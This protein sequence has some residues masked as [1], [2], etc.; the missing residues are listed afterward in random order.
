MAYFTDLAEQVSKIDKPRSKFF[1]PDGEEDDVYDEV[2]D[3]EEY[4]G[5]LMDGYE[6]DDEFADE[7]EEIAEEDEEED[8]EEEDEEDNDDAVMDGNDEI[9]GGAERRKVILREVPA[10]LSAPQDDG[11]QYGMC[12]SASL[13]ACGGGIFQGDGYHEE[14]ISKPSAVVRI[15]SELNM[16]DKR[17][18]RNEAYMSMKDKTGDTG[19]VEEVEPGEENWDKTGGHWSENNGAVDLVCFKI[20]DK[21]KQGSDCANVALVKNGQDIISKVMEKTACSVEPNTTSLYKPHDKSLSTPLRVEGFG[22]KS[23]KFETG[24]TFLVSK[25]SLSASAVEKIA[26]SVEQNTTLLYKPDNKSLSAPLVEGFLGKNKDLETSKTFLASK[27]GV[28]GIGRLMKKNYME[29]IIYAI[30]HDKIKAYSTAGTPKSTHAV[31]ASV[32]TYAV[33]DD[34]FEALTTGPFQDN[35]LSKIP[36]TLSSKSSCLTCVVREEKSYQASSTSNA[37]ASGLSSVNEESTFGSELE[38]LLT[39]HISQES[40]DDPSSYGKLLVSLEKG[41]NLETLANQGLS[42]SIAACSSAENFSFTKLFK[43]KTDGMTSSVNKTK[44]ST[45]TVKRNGKEIK[46]GR[47][48]RFDTGCAQKCI[49]TEIFLDEHQNLAQD[50]PIG[51][52]LYEDIEESSAHCCN[53]SAHEVSTPNKLMYS[54]TFSKTLAALRA[55]KSPKSVSRTRS[56]HGNLEG[57][58]S[59]PLHRAWSLSELHRKTVSFKSSEAVDKE[60]ANAQKHH[61]N[62]SEEEQPREIPSDNIYADEKCEDIPVDYRF[63][64]LTPCGTKSKPSI[65]SKGNN[66]TPFNLQDKKPQHLEVKRKFSCS[67]L[68]M[69]LSPQYFEKNK[70]D[71]ALCSQKLPEIFSTYS[72][73]KVIMMCDISAAATVH[74]SRPTSPSP[75][76]TNSVPDVRMIMKMASENYQNVTKDDKLEEMLWCDMPVSGEVDKFN[77]M[78]IYSTSAPVTSL[79]RQEGGPNLLNLQDKEDPNARV[80]NAFLSLQMPPFLSP[81]YFQEKQ[82]LCTENSKEKFSFDELYPSTEFKK[83][84]TM[85]DGSETTFRLDQHLNGMNNSILVS[86]PNSYS[87]EKSKTDADLNKKAGAQAFPVN[88]SPQNLIRDGLHTA[89]TSFKVFYENS[90]LKSVKLRPNK[91]T[92]ET[93]MPGKGPETTGIER[94]CKNLDDTA[95]SRIQTEIYKGDVGT[96]Q[97]QL[98]AGSHEAAAPND[99]EDTLSWDD[100][101]THPV[102]KNAVSAKISGSSHI[103]C[104][105]HFLNEE[106]SESETDGSLKTRDIQVYRD[107]GNKSKWFFEKGKLINPALLKEQKK[108]RGPFLRKLQENTES[109]LKAFLEVEQGSGRKHQDIKIELKQDGS[110]D[111]CQDMK[112]HSSGFELQNI[113]TKEERDKHGTGVLEALKTL[114][115]TSIRSSELQS[116]S[117][118][119]MTVSPSLDEGEFGSEM[120]QTIYDFDDMEANRTGL[121]QASKA[122]PLSRAEIQEIIFESDS[123][124]DLKIISPED[125]EQLLQNYQSS[126]L[127]ITISLPTANEGNFERDWGHGYEFNTEGMF[128]VKRGIL[129]P[130]RPVPQS[131]SIFFSRSQSNLELTV[132]SLSEACTSP[133]SSLIAAYVPKSD[134]KKTEQESLKIV[135]TKAASLETDG[136]N[137]SPKRKRKRRKLGQIG[138]KEGSCDDAELKTNTSPALMESDKSVQRKLQTNTKKEKCS[139]ERGHNRAVKT[140]VSESRM[141]RKI[142]VQSTILRKREPKTKNQVKELEQRKTMKRLKSDSKD[143]RSTG[144]AK[145]LWKECVKQCSNGAVTKM[146]ETTE[147]DLQGVRALIDP[148]ES[149]T[150][151]HRKSRKDSVLHSETLNTL[152]EK[153]HLQVYQEAKVQTD[154]GVNFAVER[155]R[156]SS[157]QGHISGGNLKCGRPKGSKCKANSCAGQRRSCSVGAQPVWLKTEVNPNSFRITSSRVFHRDT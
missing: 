47:D 138:E 122:A 86:W 61:Q 85:F 59:L 116:D 78:P 33:I 71:Q 27:Q 137:Q 60:Q 46:S 16:G 113:R 65:N 140:N 98:L 69:Y 63:A 17:E 107:K 38:E 92:P 81:Q 73:C 24:K 125:K 8:E 150:Q 96:Q 156:G 45:Q 7:D 1:N 95:A 80:S 52:K 119:C 151:R 19:L 112:F 53:G 139:K 103:I 114:G 87:S 154:G 3:D 35:T 111:S 22:G 13:R 25:R 4:P 100:V 12:A 106:T 15:C 34:T 126:T 90:M 155:F 43:E 66:Q 21:N 32:D 88:T 121:L 143:S 108:S 124:S 48:I 101:I 99:S 149:Q 147:R 76:N 57:S 30:N 94:V 91:S 41:T 84:T 14:E 109:K 23:K 67:K 26:N 39:V 134:T 127:N 97:N 2:D 83:A 56:L 75:Q 70:K 118:S 153:K 68:P 157:T 9:N 10:V 152:T 130:D 104:D 148:C 28:C 135:M 128:E 54:L 77:D 144:N 50:K 145:A 42:K 131:R 55:S 132:S 58:S 120:P 44:N 31:C 82:I 89:E 36:D 49:E 40:L 6:E 141:E 102:A 142:K 72:N 115:S 133:E 146:K 29:R 93:E 129:K 51:T 64:A 117:L 79:S 105:K 136:L 123:D 11:T 110:Q 18:V 5:G 37:C 74:S 62:I 20:D